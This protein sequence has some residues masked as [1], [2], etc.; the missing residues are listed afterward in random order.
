MDAKARRGK[1]CHI[2]SISIGVLTSD[3]ISGWPNR[4]SS[5]CQFLTIDRAREPRSLSQHRSCRDAERCVPSP[6]QTRRV[7]DRSP[8]GQ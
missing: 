2:I 3:R 7:M 1:A 8:V 4:Q 6:R 5:P